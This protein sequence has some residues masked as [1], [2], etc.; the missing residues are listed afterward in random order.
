MIKADQQMKDALTD[1]LIDWLDSKIIFEE[2]P[3]GTGVFI[4][5]NY[6]PCN[7]CSLY[8]RYYAKTIDTE[9]EKC[10]AFMAFFTSC[11]DYPVRI[12]GGFETKKAATN[13]HTIAIG[14]I[15]EII[16]KIEK[17]AQHAKCE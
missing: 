9:C 1:T 2:R 10:P 5:E 6:G 11:C 17:E 8:R 13:A 15:L 3:V 12:I 7:L 4:K 14:Y 16:D